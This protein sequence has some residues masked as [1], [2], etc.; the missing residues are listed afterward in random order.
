MVFLTQLALKRLMDLAIGVDLSKI[1]LFRKKHIL[2]CQSQ[3]A[4]ALQA[5]KGKENRFNS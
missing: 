4:D 2:S 3:S 1:S 5:S